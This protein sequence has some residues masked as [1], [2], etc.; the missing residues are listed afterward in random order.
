MAMKTKILRNM[1]TDLK[2]SKNPD[3]VA[4]NSEVCSNGPPKMAPVSERGRIL[5]T[6]MGLPQTYISYVSV[7]SWPFL[8]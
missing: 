7:E 4:G 5:L 1:D 8:H 3:V 2:I 6:V